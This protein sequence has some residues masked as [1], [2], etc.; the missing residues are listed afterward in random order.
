MYI[1]KSTICKGKQQGETEFP[2]RNCPPKR[3]D[4]TIKNRKLI[5]NYTSRDTKRKKNKKIN[6]LDIK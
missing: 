2:Y 1:Y 5:H 6:Y 3:K 4:T